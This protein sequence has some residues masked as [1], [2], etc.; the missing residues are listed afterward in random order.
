MIFKR[1]LF[2][3]MGLF[4]ITNFTP[5][6]VYAE[7]S[8][9]TCELVDGEDYFRV[10]GN[11]ANRDNYVAN[12]VVLKSEYSMADFYSFTDEEKSYCVE[13]IEPFYL[14]RNSFAV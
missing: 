11:F 4:V 12:V 8:S 6:A 7:N 9:I 10:L 2:L 14:E 13:Y 1:F 5:Y 3:L